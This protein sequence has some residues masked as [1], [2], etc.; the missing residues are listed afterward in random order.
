MKL[1]GM[2]LI[3]SELKRYRL[4]NNMTQSEVASLL[5]VKDNTITNYE[6]GTSKPNLETIITLC[7]IYRVNPVELLNE[8]F[9]ESASSASPS[10]SPASLTKL[11]QTLITSFN[12]LNHQGKRKLLDYMDDLI[13]SNRYVL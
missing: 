11:E 3:R 2:N 4:Q 13:S 7:N 5:G 10:F 1:S 8:A 12:K 6:K 9:G